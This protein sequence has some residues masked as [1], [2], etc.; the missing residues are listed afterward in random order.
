M[1]IRLS[2]VQSVAA[3][4]CYD[5]RETLKA[6]GFR[7]DSGERAWGRSVKVTELDQLLVL[8]GA[9]VDETE[10]RLAGI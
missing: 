3:Y 7:W 6:N 1:N 2:P 4:N 10:R 8:I 9:T 5:E